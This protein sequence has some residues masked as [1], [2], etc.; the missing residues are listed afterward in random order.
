MPCCFMCGPIPSSLIMDKKNYYVI[1]LCL[2]CEC[3]YQINQQI[4]VQH[5]IICRCTY[6]EGLLSG[7]CFL[8]F[9]CILNSVNS[10][11]EYLLA[12][13]GMMWQRPDSW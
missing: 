4:H 8:V 1:Y 12:L 11:S 3:P 10:T 2:D 9:W 5:I 6:E 13:C 7:H